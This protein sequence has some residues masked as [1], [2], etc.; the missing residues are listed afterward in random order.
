[1]LTKGYSQHSLPLKGQTT[2][3]FSK[4]K[5][6]PMLASTAHAQHQESVGDES[7]GD[8]VGTESQV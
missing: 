8:D 3:D 2:V 4:Q 7:V 5:E 6:S 1:M